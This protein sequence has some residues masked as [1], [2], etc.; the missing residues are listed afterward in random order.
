V[1]KNVYILTTNIAGLVVGGTVDTLWNQHQSLA[2][3]VAADIMDI[4]DWLTGQKND[5]AKLIS[6]M[7]AAIEGDLQ[8]RCMG[9]SAPARL[10]NAIRLADEAG[11]AVPK[12]RDIYQ[13][14]N[15]R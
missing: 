15:D 4:Q 14:T 12:L 13:Q 11:L 8:H 6:G 3:A 9:R 5:R 1:R 7:V 2:R 10:S